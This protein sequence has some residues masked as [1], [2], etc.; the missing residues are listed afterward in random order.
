M[1]CW[2]SRP[3]PST[4]PPFRIP[5]SCLRCGGRVELVNGTSSGT[6]SVAIVACSA[7]RIQ[8]EITLRM[9][10]HRLPEQ[11]RNAERKQRARERSSV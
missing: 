9:A 7:C 2:P 10:V 8:W 11:V 4:C 3:T 6:L 5:I 1:T